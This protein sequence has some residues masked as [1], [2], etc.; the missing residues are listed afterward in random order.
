MRPLFA[1]AFLVPVAEPDGELPEYAY[2]ESRGINVLDDGRPTVEA[3]VVGETYTLTEVRAEHEDRDVDD[4]A[5][6]AMETFTKVAREG[7]D[8]HVTELLFGTETRQVP[9]E[10]EDFARDLDGGTHTSVRAEAEDFA[11]DRDSWSA[12]PRRSDAR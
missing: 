8:R 1:D 10:R 9:S 6:L 5:L 7:T 11:R 4:K 12:S 3:G 2:D